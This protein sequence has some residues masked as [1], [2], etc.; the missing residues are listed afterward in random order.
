MRPVSV[1]LF[2]PGWWQLS[3]IV[4]DF[5]VQEWYGSIFFSLDGKFQGWVQVVD[6]KYVYMFWYS[7][8]NRSL[9]RL[10][11]CYWKT[12][13][14]KICLLNYLISLLRFQQG[15]QFPVLTHSRLLQ[16]YVL[17]MVEHHFQDKS[18]DFYF[19]SNMTQ[20]YISLYWLSSHWRGIQLV[21]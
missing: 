18:V 13:R 16:F 19:L 12:Q 17:T 1:G 3:I 15:S 14:G 6:C 9:Q 20:N 2:V 10:S 21:H 4:D 7:A 5:H 8:L 11:C